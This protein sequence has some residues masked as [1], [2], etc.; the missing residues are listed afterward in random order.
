MLTWHSGVGTHT[1]LGKQQSNSGY[2]DPITKYTSNVK[3][4]DNVSPPQIANSLVMVHSENN[5]RKLR[6]KVQKKNHNL[7][8]EFG[9]WENNQNKLYKEKDGVLI[10]VRKAQT[11]RKK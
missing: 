6:H 4:R 5:Y 7:F 1:K 3:H 9:T 10:E 2:T 11:P 8:K